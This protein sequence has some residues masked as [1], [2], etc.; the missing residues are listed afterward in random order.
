MECKYPNLFYNYSE[1]Y[2]DC[3]RESGRKPM[4]PSITDEL[5]ASLSSSIFVAFFFGVANNNLVCV[6]RLADFLSGMVS[7]ST[8]GRHLFGV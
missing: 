5:P 7:Q 1:S 3:K 6:D 8:E 4:I 2:T